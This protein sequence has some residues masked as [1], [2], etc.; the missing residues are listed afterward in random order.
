MKFALALLVTVLSTNVFA[1]DKIAKAAAAIGAQMKTHDVR[2]IV[3][4]EVNPPGSCLPDGKSY[5]VDLQVRQVKWDDIAEKKVYTWV[6]V[7]RMN[8]TQSAQTT[9]LCQ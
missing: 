6:T 7:K 4:E 1:N 8:V 3:T 9:D 5:F 2:T